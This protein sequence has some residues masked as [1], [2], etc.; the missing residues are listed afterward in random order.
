MAPTWASRALRWAEGGEGAPCASKSVE[1][2]QAACR[3]PHC[4]ADKINLSQ[5]V[6]LEGPREPH[7]R[8]DSRKGAAGSLGLISLH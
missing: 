4:P 1:F 5:V 6:S 8:A 7:T 3:T 2:L